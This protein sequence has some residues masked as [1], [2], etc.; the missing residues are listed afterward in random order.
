MARVIPELVRCG[1]ETYSRY[2]EGKQDDCFKLWG[3]D[4]CVIL[5]CNSQMRIRVILT[6]IISEID[7][8]DPLSG[9]QLFGFLFPGIVKNIYWFI[10]I[11]GFPCEQPHSFIE[12]RKKTNKPKAATDDHPVNYNSE[13]KYLI[14]ILFPCWHREVNSFLPSRIRK[15]EMSWRT[16]ILKIICRF[17]QILNITFST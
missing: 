14:Y 16:L 7:S 17:H 5:N 2:S 4:I 11:H 9:R 15:C 6:F 1:L 3:W 13:D 12:S 8:P 10:H